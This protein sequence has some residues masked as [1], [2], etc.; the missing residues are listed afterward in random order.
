MAFALQLEKGTLERSLEGLL[1]P[2]LMEQKVENT[3]VLTSTLI[4]L[5]RTGHCPALGPRG[6]QGPQK[7]CETWKLSYV[8]R[9]QFTEGEE[10]PKC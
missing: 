10:H 3:L 2:L 7:L 4:C 8:T 1:C 6:L 5:G 9:G